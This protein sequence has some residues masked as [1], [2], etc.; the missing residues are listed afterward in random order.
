MHNEELHILYTSPNFIR[1]IKSRRMRRVEHV[2]WMGDEIA[3]KSLVRKPERK[4]PLQKCR[5]TWKNN[6]RLNLKEMG[7]EGVNWIH[8][9]QGRD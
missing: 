5:H 7:W 3:Y 6:V 2:A 1:V 9:T 4:R 8:L